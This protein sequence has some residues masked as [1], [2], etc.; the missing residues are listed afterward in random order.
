MLHSPGE[1]VALIHKIA[2]NL[3][4]RRT[5][6]APPV[7]PLG[8]HMTAFRQ[9]I[10]DFAGFMDGAAAAEQETVTIVQRL[11]ALAPTLANRPD[12][13]TPAGLVPTGPAPCRGRV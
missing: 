9:A 13:A 2:G 12:P 4:R 8:G 1:T 10:T 11:A 5:L 3:R 6:S 7:S